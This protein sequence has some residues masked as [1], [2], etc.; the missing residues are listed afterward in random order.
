MKTLLQLIKNHLNNYFLNEAFKLQTCHHPWVI[1]L[2]NC[3]IPPGLFWAWLYSTGARLIWIKQRQCVCAWVTAREGRRERSLWG[4][5]GTG[6]HLTL[7]AARGLQQH[8]LPAVWKLKRHAGSAT[9]LVPEVVLR[10]QKARYLVHWWD[11][12]LQKECWMWWVGI[13]VALRVFRWPFCSHAQNCG[14]KSEMRRTK[15]ISLSATVR[16]G[17]VNLL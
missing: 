3:W 15:K 12:A 17:V 14:W 13:T 1:L 9:F 7:V 10:E 5:C 6:L 11:G 16:V 4:F 2:A 8:A